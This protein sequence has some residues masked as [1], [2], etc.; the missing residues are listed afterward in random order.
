MSD[1]AQT[2]EAV[3]LS[4][5]CKAA[6]D[7]LNDSY[8]QGKIFSSLPKQ[9]SPLS[10]LEA[11]SV[12][13]LSPRARKEIIWKYLH[14]GE[15]FSI[16]TSGILAWVA[17][18]V[19]DEYSDSEK[20]SL[21]KY[22]SVC[23]EYFDKR[24]TPDGL[25]PTD[26]G[27]SWLPH[28]YREGFLIEAQAFY[29]KVLDI[30]FLLTDDDMYEFKKKRL[31]RAVR[32]KLDGAYILDREGSLEVRPNNFI[33][34]F[35]APELF[36]RDDWQ[37]TFDVSL[38]DSELW[39]GWGGLVTL[40]QLDASYKPEVSGG[41]WFFVNNVA[42]V[43]L[44]RLDREKYSEKIQKILETSAENVSWQEHSGRPCEVTLE[45]DK[46]IKVQGLYGLSLAT[47]IYLYR[48]VS[49]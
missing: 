28:A 15:I 18:N 45:A 7:L 13:A 33:A 27:G 37:K 24:I 42:A 40:G 10:E 21:E 26:G 32:D 19:L 11:L 30:L 46:Q 43:V 3:D 20:V 22:F 16:A 35:F 39:Q 5:A 44:Y 38:K 41:S 4:S 1:V 17:I 23:E 6:S 34:A 9:G 8:K 29:A 36:K 48:M 49:T 12:L 2:K 25:L 31:I 14:S 47:F